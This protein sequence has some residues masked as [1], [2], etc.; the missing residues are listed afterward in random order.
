MDILTSDKRL[1]IRNTVKR[2]KEVHYIIIKKSIH[3]EDIAILKVYV[4]NVREPKYI[5]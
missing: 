2:D 4:L 3:Q 1:N 5:K